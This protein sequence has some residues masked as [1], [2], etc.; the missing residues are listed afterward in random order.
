[1]LVETDGVVQL[2]GGQVAP[3]DL[4]FVLGDRLAPPLVQRGRH[5]LRGAGSGEL[6]VEAAEAAAHDRGSAFRY[7]QKYQL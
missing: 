4:F 1:M 5:A 3:L 2:S 7:S 6:L